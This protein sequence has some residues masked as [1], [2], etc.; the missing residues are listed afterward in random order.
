MEQT[1]P[2]NPLVIIFLVSIVLIAIYMAIEGAVFAYNSVA[3]LAVKWGKIAARVPG[4]AQDSGAQV[5]G[6]GEPAP[7][8]PPNPHA[9]LM[10]A[11]TGGKPHLLV[12]GHTGGGKSVLTRAIARYLVDS[13][14]Q[15][16]ALDPD[17]APRHYPSPVQL[18][19][20]DEQW[21]AAIGAIA[22]LFKERNAAYRDGQERFSPA[23]LV[24]DEC[25][26]LLALDGVL[27]VVERLIRRG[28]KLNLHVLLAVQ[29]SMVRTLGLERKSALLV[30]LSRIEVLARGDSRVAVVDGAEHTVPEFPTNYDGARGSVLVLAPSAPPA[31]D[32]QQPPAWSEK[33]EQ[34][35]AILAAEP[36]IGARELARRLYG[37]DGAGKSYY[38]A[39][40]IRKDVEG[41]QDG[42]AG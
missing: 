29:D 31:L 26:E 23:W 37:G 34:A 41:R 22:D 27:P 16:V 8:A 30:N 11:I 35:A 6:A 14:A 33:H 19:S 21:T 3:R 20:D 1:L 5:E 39:M 9:A 13:G 18:L 25:Q 2:D 4:P 38:L 32:N 36:D 40:G 12:V 42:I 17:A 7:P 28:R 15:V 24:A 10:G